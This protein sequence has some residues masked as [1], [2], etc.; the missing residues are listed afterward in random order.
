MTYSDPEE[1]EE[2][3]CS[4]DIEISAVMMPKQMPRVQSSFHN[5]FQTIVNRISVEVRENTFDNTTTIMTLD[6]ILMNES[7]KRLGGKISDPLNQLM[8][9]K[10]MD[11]STQ[12]G[13]F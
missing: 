2:E 1:E 11:L 3:A 6:R 13:T 4:E 9:T 12:A 10:M 7:T 5:I 8:M